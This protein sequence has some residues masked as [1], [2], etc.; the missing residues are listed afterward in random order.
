MRRN[1]DESAYL[2]LNAFGIRLLLL[3]ADPDAGETGDLRAHKPLVDRTD[4]LD[5]DSSREPNT[6]PMRG[7]LSPKLPI[8]YL[9]SIEF[10]LN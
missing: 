8:E 5:D 2:L 1:G 6:E 10:C 7:R 4:P 9:F 3:E